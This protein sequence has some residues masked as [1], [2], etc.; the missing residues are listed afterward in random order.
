MYDLTF[1]Q[2][3]NIAKGKFEL[4]KEQV[5]RERAWIGWI[6][7]SQPTVKK[8]FDITKRV[9]FQWEVKQVKQTQEEINASLER[10]KKRDKWQ[11]KS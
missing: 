8:N 6:L 9:K 4:Y 2:L 10:I 1:R 11:R 5:E 7:S 3:D